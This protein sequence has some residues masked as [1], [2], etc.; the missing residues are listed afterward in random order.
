MK[1]QRTQTASC[2]CLCLCLFFLSD[3]VIGAEDLASK[4]AQVVEKVMPCLN[5]ATGAAAAPTKECCDATAS[6]RQSNPEC[7][8][9]IIQQTHK[10]SNEIKSLGI[11]E[12][13]LLQLG[14]TCNLKNASITNCP[15]LL[16]LPAN[17]PDA[18]IFTNSSSS[19]ATP[20]SAATTTNSSSTTQSQNDSFGSMLKPHFFN[21]VV[22]A[23]ASATVLLAF[24]V[25]E[26]IG[27]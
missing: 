15:K 5:F 8:C 27:I 14:S 12:D 1:Q 6:I 22:V 25:S 18:A 26:S 24:S 19:A 23:V 4:C 21:E 7:L 20:A 16:G 10:G 3:G 17:S 13:R 11:R 9:Y 2:L